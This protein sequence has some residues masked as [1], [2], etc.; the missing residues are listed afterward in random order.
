MSRSLYLV[1]AFTALTLLLSLAVAAPPSTL[2]PGTKAPSFTLNDVNGKSH[3]LNDYS[4]SK[5]VA[6]IFIATRC[7]VSNAYNERMVKLNDDYTSKGITFL[8]IN[9]NS[10][11]GIEE[12]KDHAGKNG[13]SF[14]VLKDPNNIVADAYGATVTP[15][16]Y[17]IDS[18]GTVRYHGRIDNS[19]DSDEISSQDLRTALDTLLSG[20]EV[21]K[22]D[23]KAFGCS[24]KRVKKQS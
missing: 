14:T 16:V 22:A 6:L 23:T 12:V 19:R 9:S 5:Y 21:A 7:P 15:E 17:V 10:Q 3:S 11:E 20:K 24:I 1:V 2:T 4:S 13:F 18:K 8:G